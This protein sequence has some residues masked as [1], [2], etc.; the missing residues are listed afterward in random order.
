MKSIVTLFGLLLLLE[1]CGP[2]PTYADNCGPMPANWRTPR[3]GMGA[4]IDL[5]YLFVEPDG[6]LVWNHGKISEP[7]LAEYLGRVALMNPLPATKVE[8]SPA[9]D[10]EAVHRIRKI[11]AEKLNCDNQICAEG[12]GKMW[13]IP[14][15]TIDGKRPEPIDPDA[16]SSNSPR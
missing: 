2:R 4:F 10:C 8:F 15:F 9:T 3:Q 12:S 6:S 1:G 11:I 5:N 14:D 16:L 13:D 7:K